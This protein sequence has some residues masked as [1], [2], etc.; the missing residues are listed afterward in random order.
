MAIFKLESFMLR[1]HV[2]VVVVAVFLSCSLFAQEKAK[3]PV[4]PA[5]WKVGDVLRYDVVEVKPQQGNPENPLT[6]KRRIE[7]KTV[8]ANDKGHVVEWRTIKSEVPKIDAP[9]PGGMNFDIAGFQQKLMSISDSLVYRFQTAKDGRLESI[10]NRKDVE[11]KF[12]E[13]MDSII[14]AFEKSAGGEKE[15]QAAGMII[16]MLESTMNVETFTAGAITEAEPLISMIG[17]EVEKGHVVKDVV[18]MPLPGAQGL[19]IEADRRIEIKEYDAATGRTNVAVKIVADPEK[20]AKAMIQFIGDMMKKMGVDEEIDPAQI[21]ELKMTTDIVIVVD[22]KT[23]VL[24]SFESNGLVES[25]ETTQSIKK[26]F[27]LAPKET[28]E[29]K[30]EAQAESRPAK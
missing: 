4:V 5:P 16:Q 24:Q 29:T 17:A 18:K 15:S 26:S 28:T 14:A 25:G 10:V 12:K 21:P 1:L 13:M 20:A 8:E 2:V 7:V 22:A 19:E 27:K 6:T 23:G 11:E 3:K 30:S 9:A